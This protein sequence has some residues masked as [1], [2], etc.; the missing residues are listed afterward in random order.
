MGFAG[1]KAYMNVVEVNNGGIGWLPEC[2][3]SDC[4]HA[5]VAWKECL[6]EPHKKLILT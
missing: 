5:W 4:V 1:F 3:V 2:S 6:S